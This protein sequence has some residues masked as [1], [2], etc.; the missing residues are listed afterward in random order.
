[1][2]EN[3][4]KKPISKWLII[5]L[6][7]CLLAA[8]AACVFF[9]SGSDPQKEPLRESKLYWNVEGKSFRNG[10]NIRYVSDDGYVY[11]IFSVDGKQE[12]IPV[13]NYELATAIDMLDVV[14]LEFDKNGVAVDYLRVAEFTGGIVANKFFVTA[15]EGNRITCNSSVT[16]AGYDVILEITD[17]TPIYDV[18]TE[19]ITCGIPGK[20]KVQDQVTVVQDQDGSVQCVYVYSYVQ[21]GDLYWSVSR[22]YD[23]FVRRTTREPDELG[24]YS[25]E[26]L[27]NGETVTVRTRDYEVA[28]QMDS[29][30]AP[31][32]GLSFDE[33]GYVIEAVHATKV[34]EGRVFAS[35]SRVM[36]VSGNMLYTK[37][38]TGSGVGTE[39]S[40]L[41]SEDCKIINT[42]SAGTRGEY[43]DL[44]YGD[45]IHA[46]TD[47]RGKLCY[48]FI[49]S[50]VCV[51]EYGFCWNFD[52]K[53]GATETERKPDA[54]GV[55]HIKLACDGEVFTGW[56]KDIDKVNMLD[57]SRFR[58]VKLGE[59][60]EILDVIASNYVYGGSYF[61]SWYY[62]DKIEGDQITVSF[63][64]NMDSEKKT[65]T[66]TL[67][68]N[69]QVYNTSQV[70][71]SYAG[72]VSDLRVGDQIYAQNDMYGQ[73]RSI[74]VVN[75]YLRTG[76]YYNLER[77]WNDT[78]KCTTRTPDENGVYTI[79]MAYNG[80]QV[81][82][83]TKSR[84]VANDIDSQ[85]AN[86]LGLVMDKNGY[87]IKAVHANQ[88]EECK[89]G[90]SVSY[91]LVTGI[92]GNRISTYKENNGQRKTITLT[93]DVKFI[94]VSSLYDEYKGEYTKLRVGDKI[95]CLM[96]QDKNTNYVFITSR[97]PV[98]Q[99]HSCQHAPADTKWYT[100]NGKT[101]FTESGHYVLTEDIE[102]SKRVTIKA[103]QDITLCLN[104]HTLTCSD[105]VF[106]VYGNLTLCDH[107]QEDG[108]YKGSIITSYS[109]V[110]DSEG[111][112]TADVYGGLA[113]LYNE[114]QDVSLTIRGGN[115]IHTGEVTSA[116]HVYVANKSDSGFS[117]VFS[118]YD[119]VLTGG[120]A[121]ESGGAV[122]VRNVGVFNMYGGTITDCYAKTGAGVHM[123][124][125]NAEFR[126]EDGVI[127][128]CHGT[129]VGAGVCVGNGTAYMTGGTI[130]GCTTTGNGGSVNVTAG[131]FTMTGGSLV[132]GEAKEGGNLRIGSAASVT[133]G[134]EAR[135]AD[136]TA[137]NGGNALVY[138][139]LLIQDNAVIENGAATNK[140]GNINAFAN[141][142]EATA[143]I[144]MTGG[145]ISGG[146]AVADSGSVRLD[147]NAGTVNMT[148]TGGSITGGSAPHGPCVKVG[149]AEHI[150]M[151][152]GGTAVIDQV[153]LENGKSMAVHAD[154]LAETAS[155]TVAVSD[156]T[157]PFVTIT[158]PAMEGVFHPYDRETAKIVN[159]DNSLYLEVAHIH[160]VCGGN[161]TGAALEAHSCTEAV[162][163]VGV[164]QTDFAVGGIFVNAST[165]GRVNFKEQKA[166]Y[167]LTESV[168]TSSV[169]EILK[170][171][172]ITICLNGHT[173]TSTATGNSAIRLSGKL[174][175][176]DCQGGGKIT[177]KSPKAPGLIFMVTK[178]ADSTE[179]TILNLYGGDLT[180][181]D[182]NYTAN[183]GVI[184]VGNTG[185]NPGV[186]NMYGGSISGG[187][188][189]KGGNILIGTAA[190]TMNLYGGSV[191]DGSVK[192]ND[193]STDRNR[194]GNI[195]VNKGTLNV[196]GGIIS[197][198]KTTADDPNPGLGGDIYLTGGKVQFYVPMEGQD[199]VNDGTGQLIWPDTGSDRED[200]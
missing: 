135:I 53:S 32:M 68:K 21:P 96:D 15:I 54:N 124:S 194:G 66:G 144:I 8:A 161:L 24:C 29:F 182:N 83:Q 175:I 88:T 17:Q 141:L 176:C 139:T 111:K 22:K 33:N 30:N 152:V 193:S 131:S 167:Y 171:T 78:D 44:R 114:T 19:G 43:T 12:R 5:V 195:Y 126:M 134:G 168:T 138:G 103:G 14:G 99:E 72:E 173:I 25:Y 89:G 52:Y 91:V 156:T 147:A 11:M 189:N 69:V 142:E 159:V 184:Q 154:G 18:G 157:K 155:I 119:G 46:L 36:Q 160:C 67:S 150:Y 191:V 120:R 77:K 105:R 128:N 102:L 109:N 90:V 16:L 113:Y 35:Y 163:W 73:I 110:V 13:A 85:V 79:K 166:V 179:G 101:A 37:K 185:N 28:C 62:V 190:A 95:H 104:G 7:A 112:I 132:G 86:V 20:V 47:G 186:F 137:T 172:D 84:K 61:C 151:T 2:K 115:Y 80:K 60:N 92:S 136:G 97:K 40:A 65:L 121:T 82:V 34:T 38:L 42:T 27:C 199:I 3:K 74:Y 71:S 6:A 117:A 178:D 180:V 108:S 188:A 31:C 94:N 145:T 164:S 56:T 106:S 197:G 170:G 81:L 76:V 100:W 41:L 55:Y 146:T 58:G 59:D 125:A 158:D 153:Y 200:P 50:R 98:A 130:T 122:A 181:T 4:E 118:L 75:R 45:Q 143:N 26:M 196:Y 51:E 183:A 149:S 129:D 187:T 23:S 87:C 63:R 165:T 148:V 9:L 1:M 93:S 107:K 70:V 123:Q 48:V 177:G 39:Y 162:E 49:T 57:T 169:L 198:G 116:G 192:T 127:T 140:G 10:T 64:K 174:T 133:L